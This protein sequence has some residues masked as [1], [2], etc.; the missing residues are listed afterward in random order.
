VYTIPTGISMLVWV[1]RRNNPQNR[2]QCPSVVLNRKEQT[3]IL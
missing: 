1:V 2:D 3:R